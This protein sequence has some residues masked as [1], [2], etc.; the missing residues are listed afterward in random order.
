MINLG[1]QPFQMEIGSKTQ[2]LLVIKEEAPD[3]EY[4]LIESGNPNIL[5][6]ADENGFKKI[7]KQYE[8][9]MFSP[10]GGRKLQSFYSRVHIVHIEDIREE[11]TQI[12]ALGNRNARVRVEPLR[13]SIKITLLSR[14]HEFKSDLMRGIEDEEERRGGTK[15]INL[16]FLPFQTEIKS[17]TLDLG[18][19]METDPDAIY[20]LIETPDPNVIYIADE[21]G[22][23][24][25][26]DQINGENN[27]PAERERLRVFYQTVHAVQFRDFGEELD[28]ILRCGNKTVPVLVE[29]MLNSI[30]VTVLTDKPAL[31]PDNVSENDGIN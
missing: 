31:R 13:Y 4:Y 11:I 2:E 7:S 29:P 21:D 25:I 1:F 19:I 12:L 26:S 27:T 6:V 3:D 24:R 18:D 30:K 17:N 8:D 15:M 16:D 5:Y 23:R 10:E 28:L 22:F 14:M 20:C 9:E